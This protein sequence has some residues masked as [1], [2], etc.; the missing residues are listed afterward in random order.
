[1]HEY[2]FE[3][4]SILVSIVSIY[5]S[6]KDYKDFLELVVQDERA[7]KIENFERVVK[8]KDDG[9]ISIDYE[10]YADYKVLVENLK[11]IEKDIKAKQV[12]YD[13]APEEF[14]D[15]I[16]ATLMEDPVK[17]PSSGVI[18]DRTTIET[19]LLSDPTDP[20]NR[21]ALRKEELIPC[22]DLQVKILE[23][24]KYKLQK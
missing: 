5:V 12:N 1:M 23:Y 9:K 13:D 14:L 19:H 22:P 18:V 15:P 24:K 2:G 20:F 11:V 3:P 4:K 10:K 21:S 8:L 17:L 16:A 7:F 6:F